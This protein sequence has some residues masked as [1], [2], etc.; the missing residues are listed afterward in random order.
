MAAA[1]RPGHR[2]DR[3]LQPGARRRR[4]VFNAGDIILGGDGSDL[5]QGNAGDDII[6]G[7][8]WL[9]VLIASMPT[10][11]NGGTGGLAE[12]ARATTA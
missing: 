9:N 10:G 4:H 1:R 12:V 11:P 2:A 6:D 5:I 8:K 3:G 7:D